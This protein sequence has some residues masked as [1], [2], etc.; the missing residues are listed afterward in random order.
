M[1]QLFILHDHLK[2]VL[3]VRVRNKV[4]A[5]RMSGEADLGGDK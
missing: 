3:G 4:K 2:E 1:K 5:A